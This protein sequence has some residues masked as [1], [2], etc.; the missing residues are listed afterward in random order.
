[1]SEHTALG[2]DDVRKHFPE[3]KFD[4]FNQQ[5]EDWK[6]QIEEA[7]QKARNG[8]VGKEIKQCITFGKDR[9]ENPT[10]FWTIFAKC[11]LYVKGWPL[12][13]C[14]PLFNIDIAENI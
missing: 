5:D 14:M 8:C 11:H 12:H 13:N 1:M 10:E 9:H 3:F 6:T 7:E 4:I 2:D